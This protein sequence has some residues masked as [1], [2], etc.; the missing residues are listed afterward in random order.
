MSQGQTWLITGGAGYI[1]SHIADEFIKAG[2]S[3]VIYVVNVGWIL[4]R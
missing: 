3:V 4:F 1:G 2:K